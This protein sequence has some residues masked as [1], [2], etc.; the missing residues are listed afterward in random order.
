[1]TH[2]KLKIAVTVISLSACAVANAQ[3]SPI[4]PSYQYPAAPPQSGAASVQLPDTP[5]FFT[6]YVGLAVG[7]D[8]NVL[9]TNTN[10]TSSTLYIVSPGFKL[11]ARAPGIVYQGSYQGVI[12]QYQDSSDDDYVD[13]FVRN[14]LD[15]AF[16]GRSFL[17]MGFDYT[18]G[19]DPRGSTDRGIST[20]PDK[21]QLISP[22]ATYAFGAPG[23]Q[24]RMELYWTDG[25]KTYLNNP[26][27]TSLSNRD[28]R[29]LGSAFYWRVMPK[30][31]LLVDFRDTN[32]HYRSS[33]SDQSS[34]EKRY[35]VGVTWDATALTS[36]TFKVG[37]LKKEF[38]DPTVP[39]FSGTSWEGTITWAPR[40]YSTVDFYTART[41]N[42]STGLGT[43]I[44]SDIYGVS[45]NH[46]WS[47]VVSTGVN[48]RHQRDEYQGFDR[49]DK[50]NILGLKAAYKFRRWLT[51]GAEYVYTKRDSNQNTF[52]YD[53]NL[54]LLTA[55]ASM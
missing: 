17:R 4:R 28:T 33:A 40:T 26:S 7:H 12:G 22:S 34:E 29:D 35:L 2:K 50:T 23:A 38:D 45:W 10:K 18:H 31:Y 48:L 51:F 49:T 44:L 24:G 1:M 11:D 55:T 47:S 41:A 27:T 19:H 20:S 8:D 9:L 14:Q 5:V 15:L 32:I 21:Y 25:Y 37:R 16:S 43:F 39:G 46:S 36:G 54:Y 30:T 42:E 6:P 3:T 13:N 53:K 52:D